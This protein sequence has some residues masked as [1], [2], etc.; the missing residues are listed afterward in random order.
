L[1]VSALIKTGGFVGVKI[2]R[3][4]VFGRERKK[5]RKRFFKKRLFVVEKTAQEYNIK[6]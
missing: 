2:F 4:K 6:V 3:E 5:K 1:F